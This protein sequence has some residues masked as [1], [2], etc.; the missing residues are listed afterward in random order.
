M[1]KCPT[2]A[3]LVLLI[4]C[5]VIPSVHGYTI[6]GKPSQTYPNPMLADTVIDFPSRGYAT[7]SGFRAYGGDTFAGGQHLCGD[8]NGHCIRIVHND[9]T[10][11][12]WFE[13]YEK[14]CLPNV[15]D[16]P[17]AAAVNALGFRLFVGVDI[18]EVD[19]R[20]PDGPSGALLSINLCSGGG[21][22]LKYSSTGSGSSPLVCAVDAPGV[23]ELG[24]T[25]VS[26][27]VL[28]PAVVVCTGGGDSDIRVSVQGAS[29][30][31]PV[32]G[33]ELWTSVPDRAFH[34]TGDGAPLNVDLSV[35]ATVN[36]P[37]PGFYS[38]TFVYTIEYL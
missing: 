10:K 38:G 4:A 3:L 22:D 25:T 35:G 26:T 27:T 32:P 29:T 33:L 11:T 20:V 17:L 14:G 13:K 9:G 28:V 31:R 30:I 36:G 16:G 19:Y 15:G 2:A 34:V 24:R 23:V 6:G 21:Y 37:E 7:L 18:P 1:K 8:T 5:A 12:R